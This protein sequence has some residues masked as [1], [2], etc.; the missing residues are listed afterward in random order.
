MTEQQVTKAAQRKGAGKVERKAQALERLRVEYVEIDEV[1]PNSYNPNRQAEQDFTLLKRSI[2]EDGFTQPIV[3]HRD[4]KVIV[5]GEHR[6][7]AAR[8]LGMQRVPVV[9]VDMSDEQMRIATLR[10]NR[11]R[12]S[13]DVELG[14]QLLRDLRELGALDWAADSLGLD[15][16]ELTLMLNDLPVPELLAGE[17][18]GEAWTPTKAASE[19]LTKNTP[20]ERVDMTPAA[21]IRAEEQ[22]K[23]VAAATTAPER[24]KLEMASR[25]QSYRVVIVFKGDEAAQVRAA[26]EPRPAVA[27]LELCRAATAAFGAELQVAN[28]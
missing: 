23:L 27:L 28:G 18:Y 5:D 10:H 26:L 12:G 3:A 22:K 13:E 2:T 21:V 1:K 24:Q 7:R 19:N 16:K 25:S 14:A 20:A 9:F 8:D 11:A 17:E 6:W 15:E 4:T